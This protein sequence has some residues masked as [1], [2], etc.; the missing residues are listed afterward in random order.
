MMTLPSAFIQLVGQESSL[1]S[2]SLASTVVPDFTN[3]TLLESLVASGWTMNSW[4]LLQPCASSL[5]LVSIY[6]L[7]DVSS[8]FSN[9]IALESAT[10][11]AFYTQTDNLT[12]PRN[13]ASLSVR[14]AQSGL[15]ALVATGNKF[16]QLNWNG[17][18][19]YAPATP[20]VPGTVKALVYTTTVKG[21]GGL[22]FTFPPSLE[23]LTIG[24]GNWS[25]NAVIDASLA[26]C[27][28]LSSLSIDVSSSGNLTE[29]IALLPSLR[30]TNITKLTLKTS[31]AEGISLESAT[32]MLCTLVDG[33]RLVSLSLGG[34]IPYLPDCNVSSPYPALKAFSAT[35]LAVALAP[36][37]IDFS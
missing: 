36:W 34:G 28:N 6:Q 32:E 22:N 13:L 27:Q 18:R 9:M 21:L 4:S 20:S 17:N 16:T 19:P 23:S 15:P 37:H 12:L 29:V 10:F 24:V 11:S 31:Q 26:Q 2:L 3:L 1:K 30:N 35:S 14:F 8:A 5:R 7:L 25:A 33:T